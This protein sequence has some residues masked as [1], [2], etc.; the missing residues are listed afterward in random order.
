M[1]GGRSVGGHVRLTCFESRD[2]RRRH[3]GPKVAGGKMPA[4]VT[5]PAMR[6]RLGPGPTETGRETESLVIDPGDSCD[7]R[8]DPSTS[9]AVSEVVQS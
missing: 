1:R 5:R 6:T 4:A 3:Y 9:G 7:I 8:L 2:L